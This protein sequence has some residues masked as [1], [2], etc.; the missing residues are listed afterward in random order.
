MNLEDQARLDISPELVD[1][2]K[3]FPVR[4]AIEHCGARISASPFDFY[5]DC[6]RCGTRIKVRSFSAATE[7]EDVFDAVFE[8]MS[9]PAA[10]EIATRRQQAIEADR[11]EPFLPT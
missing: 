8:W 3:S 4:R 5:V 2:L 7:I 6:P 10:R 1:A 11:D 9:D